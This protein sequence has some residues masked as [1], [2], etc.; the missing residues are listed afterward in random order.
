MQ[1]TQLYPFQLF[2]QLL[3]LSLWVQNRN[4]LCTA[5]HRFNHFVSWR[6]LSSIYSYLNSQTVH[7]AWIHALIYLDILRWRLCRWEQL[8]MEHIHRIS[9]LIYLLS[10]LI[11]R[12]LFLFLS[13][14]FHHHRHQ[15]NLPFLLRYY[16]L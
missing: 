5:T 15:L 9:R 3:S 11:V 7:Q 10:Q 8:I 4:L 2:I 6:F 16:H 1:F 12:I 13:F 14:C